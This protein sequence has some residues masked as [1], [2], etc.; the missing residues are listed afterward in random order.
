M[1]DLPAATALL[2]AAPAPAASV[3]P[4]RVVLDYDARLMRRK[5][6]MTEGGRG[7]LVDLPTVTNL[8]EYWGFALADGTNVQIVAAEEPVLLITA[9]P[10]AP[11]S[12]LAWHIGNRHT[13]CEIHADCLVIREDHV[14][15]AMLRRLGAGV[16][17]V[18]RP[19]RPESG[20]YGTGRTMGHDH[21]HSHAH[22]HDQG[23]SHDHVHGHH[24]DDVHGHYHAPLPPHARR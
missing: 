1:T 7:F 11:L 12:R 24:H 8:D 10:A 21:G 20:A 19:F 9:G 23:H 4:E 22:G 3:P 17:R 15:E 6:L 14:L 13:P 5:R 2:G 16:T 18:R